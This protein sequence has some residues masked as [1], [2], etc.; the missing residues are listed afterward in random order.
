[1]DVLALRLQ[2]KCPYEAGERDMIVLHH[3]FEAAYEGEAREHITSTLVDYGVPGGDSAM[4]R[5]VSLPAAIAAR[6]ILEGRI[7]L[8]GVQIPVL[9]EV[10]DPVLDELETLGIKCE[11]AT[12]PAS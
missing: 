6:L 11:E 5:T 9:P 7:N 2:E 4:A 12:R 1:M 3:E 8:A 10:Y